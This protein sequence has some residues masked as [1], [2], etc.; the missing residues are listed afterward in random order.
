MRRTP[1]EILL[2]VEE[3]K[4]RTQSLRDRMDKDYRRWRLE[5]YDGQEED[6][7]VYTSNAPRAFANKVTSLLSS[8][9][10]LIRIPQEK[11]QREERKQHNEK[12]RFYI[13]V[14]RANDERLLRLGLPTLQDQL[15]WYSPMRG[16]VLGRALLRKQKDGATV[17]DVTPWDIRHSYWGMGPDGL[18]WACQRLKKT[19]LEIKTQYG[20]DI[21]GS[22]PDEEDGGFD[23][24]DFYDDVHNTVIMK[25]HVLKR[26][27]PHGSPR[28][29][30]FFS[31][32]GT[33]PPI[34][35]DPVGD[36]LKDYGD[37]IY[38]ANRNIW[39]KNNFIMSVMTELT[40]RAQ[41]GSYIIQ[42]PGGQKTL[43]KNPYEEGSEIPLGLQD[44]IEQL[45]LMEMAKETGAFLGRVSGEDQRGSLSHT[46]YGAVP[47]TL[48]GFAINS[49]K[50][51]IF[52]SIEPALKAI[53]NAYFQI[54]LLLSDQYATGRFQ[55]MEVSGQDR[56]RKYFRAEITP[57]MV[58]G[59][60]NPVVD[61]LA[62]LP[63][64]E[65]AMYQMA[66]LARDTSAGKPPMMP[67]KH[68]L[69]NILKLQDVDE[70]QD[71][72]KAEQAER[73]SP[74]AAA[75][76]L[77][78]ATA[79]Q[80]MEDLSNIYMGEIEIQ[81]LRKQLEIAQLRMAAM[82]MAQNPP[83]EASAGGARGNGDRPGLTSNVAPAPTQGIPTP[84]PTPQAGP[85]VP[86]GTPRPGAQQ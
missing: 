12:E 40:A 53:V 57:E 85:I 56:N 74:L 22:D 58:K 49:L 75:Y 14:L 39:D 27:T 48:S 2:M 9:K 73:A 43:D 79:E 44:K 62:S 68:V 7:R 29:P 78:M 10:I 6:F 86:P 46:A 59:G 30:V 66:Q 32:V 13:G 41:K 34:L 23:V 64:D 25:D 21:E 50:Q 55:A 54:C 80:G 51:D 24:Y 82:G 83:G 15:S 77:G 20:M 38:Q 35:S 67:D 18:M 31:V 42:S 8:G 17:V 65:P 47:F 19:K 76:T 71:M 33:A 3:Q 60:A 4:K 69:E 37:S 84:Q 45:G 28:I 52:T 63:Q 61:L 26:P 1:E 81:I 36:T 11:E 72:L 70:L 5:E 16:W